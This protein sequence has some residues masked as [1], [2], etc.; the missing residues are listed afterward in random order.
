MKP[1]ITASAARVFGGVAKSKTRPPVRNVDLRISKEIEQMYGLEAFDR[2]KLAVYKMVPGGDRLVLSE[3]V[4]QV[5][6]RLR[7]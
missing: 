4:R 7:R 2:M 3:K 5:A 1:G 6:E